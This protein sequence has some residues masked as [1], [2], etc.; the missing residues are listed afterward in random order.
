M[1]YFVKYS[2]FDDFNKYLNILIYEIIKGIE[3]YK[4]L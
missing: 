2:L 1:K 3:S 4:K